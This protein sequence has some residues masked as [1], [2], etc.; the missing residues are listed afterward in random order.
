MTRLSPAVT[1]T[2]AVLDFFAAHP[3]QSFTLTDIVTSLR[4]SRATCHALLAALVEAGYL[5]RDSDKNYGL[6]PALAAIG[7]IALEHFSPLQ[8]ARP[9][10]R[11]LANDYDVVCSALFRDRDEI[12][13]R[14]WAASASHHTWLLSHP[15]RY[16]LV[17]PMG[18]VFLAWS[19]PKEV[20][21]WLDKVQPPLS[22]KVQ[23]ELRESLEFVKSCGFAFG[24]RRVPIQTA[25]R[26]QELMGSS[27]LTAYAVTELD[28]KRSYELA[29]VVAP[30]LDAQER[31]VFA[32]ALNGFI[33]PERGADIEKIGKRLRASCDA[34]A[35]F[36]A[37]RSSA[38][39]SS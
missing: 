22:K 2:V 38:R 29:F 17:P 21:R 6:G 39:A 32:L 12:V 19:S 11:K 8:L 28:H 31:L 7:R 1:R 23:Q 13:N 9:E 30:V 24:Y 37:G 33:K 5:Y 26:A 15:R 20:D 3:E 18:N 14:E 16:P 36:I 25:D 4:I 27:T 35:A 10:M 34:I